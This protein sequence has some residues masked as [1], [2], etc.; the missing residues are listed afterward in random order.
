VSGSWT[1]VWVPIV[2]K[3]E[4]EAGKDKSPAIWAFIFSED[5]HN[6]QEVRNRFDRP[7]LRGLVN[8][9]APKPGIIAGALIKKIYPGTD[10]NKCII[11]EEGKEPAGVLK[12][13]L[14]A[15]GFVFLIGLTPGI[16]F[17]ARKLDKVELEAKL[18]KRRNP[19][20]SQNQPMEVEP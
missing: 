3:D 15:I 5:V 20:I 4:D 1:K 2:P 19:G 11:I 7:Y 13:A 6:D 16:W 12:L 18:S 10:P 8:P 14:Y 9:H 17:L